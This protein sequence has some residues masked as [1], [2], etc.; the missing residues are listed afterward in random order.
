MTHDLAPGQHM[1]V[2]DVCRVPVKDLS[3]SVTKEYL[4]KVLTFCSHACLKVY[5]DDP[6]MY[7]SFED[8]EG[9]E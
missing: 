5:T 1:D 2:C 7:A 3:T 9:L 8:D 6:E 4:G